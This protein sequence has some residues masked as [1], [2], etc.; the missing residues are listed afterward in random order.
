[1]KL[2]VSLNGLLLFICVQLFLPAAQNP[3]HAQENNADGSYLIAVATIDKT[4][5]HWGFIDYTGTEV[6]PLKY[7]YTKPF[8]DGLAVVANKD[9]KFGYIN[10][11]GE[12][13]IPL[14]YENPSKPFAEGLAC[15]RKNGKYGFIDIAGNV[16]IDFQYSTAGPGFSNGLAAVG[17]ST[18]TMG[19][20][21]R[22]GNRVIPFVYTNPLQFQN[23]LAPVQKKGTWGFIDKTG[24][25]VVDFQFDRVSDFSEDMIWVRNDDMKVGYL[26]TRGEISV[27]FDYNFAVPF[28]NNSAFV[29]TGGSLT[30]DS[31]GMIDKTGNWIV[32]FAYPDIYTSYS[33]CEGLAR[34]RHVKMSPQKCGYIDKTGKVVIP[35]QYQDALAFSNGYAGVRMNNKW[36]LIDKSGT[37]RVACKYDWFVYNK[38]FW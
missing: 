2:Q 4:G 9:E 37:L 11:Q 25:V 38:C 19:Y 32:K 7:T 12:V 14:I 26:N 1:M 34:V 8:T 21:D 20:I 31:W 30:T 13:V 10:P 16:V 29:K 36:G 24:K 17:N 6:I 35:V 27:P 15:V 3:I 23:G 22:N 5:E 28:H 18:T 33:F